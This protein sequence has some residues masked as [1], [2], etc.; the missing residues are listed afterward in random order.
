MKTASSPGHD[1]PSTLTESYKGGGGGWGA[2]PVVGGRSPRLR[3]GLGAGGGG[4]EWLKFPLG[5]GGQIQPEPASQ[6]LP[7]GNTA[8]R[9]D[10]ADR[11][12]A[13]ASG[14]L[15]VAFSIDPRVQALGGGA[16]SDPQAG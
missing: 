1:S 9:I 8:S 4:G 6:S 11:L 2:C 5:E 16:Q 10:G 13:W 7:K 15:R 3:V 12:L 14:V